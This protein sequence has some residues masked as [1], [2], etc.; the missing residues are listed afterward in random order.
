MSLKRKLRHA[1]GIKSYTYDGNAILGQGALHLEN[2]QRLKYTMVLKY[3]FLE[4]RLLVAVACAMPLHQ[5][6]DKNR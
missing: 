3:V 1:K 2:K 5:E 6:N 4:L